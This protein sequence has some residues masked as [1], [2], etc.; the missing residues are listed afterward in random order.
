[1]VLSSAVAD[2]DNQVM[3]HG[4]KLEAL[5]AI[6]K[7]I[8]NL[9]KAEI[10]QA[11]KKLEDLCLRILFQEC[12]H[13]LVR[14][15]V[16]VLSQ[17]YSRGTNSAMHACVAFLFQLCVY[18][19]P[20]GQLDRPIPGNEDSTED[21][22]V[23]IHER[24]VCFSI[25]VGI[26]VSKGPSASYFVPNILGAA[27][28]LMKLPD[29][30]ARESVLRNL[31][32]VI[33]IIGVPGTKVGEE[34]YSQLLYRTLYSDKSPQVRI[35]AAYGLASFCAKCKSVAIANSETIQSLCLKL[36]LAPADQLMESSG[37]TGN[38]LV[39]ARNALSEILLQLSLAII[40]TNKGEKSIPEKPVGHLLKSAVNFQTALA[41][42]MNWIRKYRNSSISTSHYVFECISS[43]AIRLAIAL[44]EREEDL[45]LLARSVVEEISLIS[46]SIAGR[47]IQRILRSGEGDSGVLRIVSE[48]LM[49]FIRSPGTVAEAS[50]VVCL[51]GLVEAMAI[52]ES[53]ICA[54]DSEIGSDLVQLS[55]FC[56]NSTAVA[57]NC[58]YALRSL[59]RVSPS[60]SFSLVN[61]LLNHVTIQNAELA[62]ADKSTQHLF[63]KSILHYAIALSSVLCECADS[64]PQDVSAAVQATAASLICGGQSAEEG[65]N[66]VGEWQRKSCGFILLVPLVKDAGDRSLVTLFSLWKSV[67]GKKTKD[68]LIQAIAPGTVIDDIGPIMECFQ[69]IL[70]ALRSLFAFA[71]CAGAEK[72]QGDT[73][74]MLLVLL[75][76]VWQIT[77]AAVPLESSTVDTNPSLS[78]L[79]HAIRAELYKTLLALQDEQLES[80][81]KPLA[82][83][84]STEVARQD[85]AN[86][87]VF[88]CSSSLLFE[89]VTGHQR[90]DY[91]F[92]P[93]IVDVQDSIFENQ[94]V[95][96]EYA[97]A[98]A[99]NAGLKAMF[100]DKTVPIRD[101]YASPICMGALEEFHSY[102]PASTGSPFCPIFPYL[103][104]D[105]LRPLS[106][107]MVH[108]VTEAR[109]T[110]I[111]LLSR[112][113]GLVD[114]GTCDACISVL[115]SAYR[116]VDQVSSV[117]YEDENFPGKS[118]F[119]IRSNPVVA[120]VA[121][122][123]VVL[124]LSERA[125]SVSESASS[126]LLSVAASPLGLGALHP[127]TRR[128]A[129]GMIAAIY[130]SKPSF[131]DAIFQCVTDSAVSSTARTRSGTAL[132]IANLV[133]VSPM[134]SLTTM[135]SSLFKLTRELT[136]PTRA[137]ALFA[138]MSV[139]SSARASI[140]PWT[141]E[142]VKVAT[143]HAVADIYP[144]ALSTMLLS[145]VVAAIGPVA[146]TWPQTEGSCRC[147]LIWEAIRNG[148]SDVGGQNKTYAIISERF[149][150][151]FASTQ[152]SNATAYVID[153]IGSSIETN[154]AVCRC[155]II[156]LCE[157]LS[158]SAQK[159]SV[160]FYDAL[161]SVCDVNPPLR[162]EVDKLLKV[163]LRSQSMP[164]LMHI[165]N[166]LSSNNTQGGMEEA[167]D[168]DDD[169]DDDYDDG[170]VESPAS[171][172]HHKSATNRS[173][174]RP[175]TVATKAL[176]IKC[177]K[178][179]MKSPLFVKR[180][181]VVEKIVS[182]SVAAMGESSHS[183]AVQGIKLLSLVIDVFGDDVS[184]RPSRYV[185][186]DSDS[187]ASP[188]SDVWDGPVPLLLQFETQIMSALRR[189][190]K[191]NSDCSPQV[192]KICLQIFRK[193]FEKKLT[194]NPE[195]LVELLVQPLV[196]VDPS[197][198]PWS[199]YF[200]L[201]EAGN[202]I[203]SGRS[204]QTAEREVS[205][206]L[207]T[208]MAVIVDVLD[209]AL[210]NGLDVVVNEFRRNSEFIHYYFLR[211]LIDCAAVINGM[212][213]LAY[214]S[215]IE[216][217]RAAL[218][219]SIK[220]LL[221]PT[222]LNGLAISR[223][224]EWGKIWCPL[225]CPVKGV[226][227][228]EAFYVAVTRQLIEDSLESLS[229]VKM[230]TLVRPIE[231]C[232]FELKEEHRD[233]SMLSFFAASVPVGADRQCPQ[234]EMTRF[235]HDL[236]SSHE[237][238]ARPRMNIVWNL[239]AGNFGFDDGLMSDIFLWL[240]QNGYFSTSQEKM[241][242][243]VAECLL[244]LVMKNPQGT[245]KLVRDMT[246]HKGTIQSLSSAVIDLFCQ[247]D[248][249]Q[250]QFALVLLIPVF[251]RSV[252][253]VDVDQL[254]KLRR[255]IAHSKNLSLMCQL[256]VK[257]MQATPP[258]PIVSAFHLPVCLDLLL[259]DR[260]EALVV[261]QPLALV[262][263]AHK[264]STEWASF[265]AAIMSMTCRQENSEAEEDIIGKC[266]ITCMQMSIDVFKAAIAELSAEDKGLVEVVV[267]KH[268]PRR[269]QSS[270]KRDE[271]GTSAPSGTSNAP[272]I[273]LKLKFGQ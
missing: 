145:G 32:S 117:D 223:K 17:C 73:S 128:M 90:T 108:P 237:D 54:L 34:V 50:L 65:V 229:V 109:V 38:L 75:N 56:V 77:Q 91:F 261:L 193:I 25:A 137:C 63:I 130:F 270:S 85:A 151:G 244:P 82:A 228:M 72:L 169:E 58:A 87:A 114:K 258:L 264:E 101:Y 35:A 205:L 136:L 159:I 119:V 148:V 8:P 15:I 216:S 106:D 230:A 20:K 171:V 61:V 51:V 236:I 59:C 122:T 172:G 124:F 98:V 197:S 165:L 125:H 190:V 221:A 76:N 66:S 168:D 268:V 177:V 255:A 225:D 239:T 55:T 162:P 53:S 220:S 227:D 99:V 152:S 222:V 92:S 5:S 266:L 194:S 131:R 107:Q 48:V 217:D 198:L 79:V 263:G 70:V 40:E 187:N 191:T 39:E 173:I 254:S 218:E 158:T 29:P 208:R 209:F 22:N 78:L 161:F 163:L 183:L 233:S 246:E 110:G 43:L 2:A 252:D 102:F 120:A 83:F 215:L 154:S 14:L 267:R 9:P 68:D 256:M 253:N 118:S 206:I 127:M 155:A 199:T 142:V 134:G 203:L 200:V 10:I 135:S 23:S 167:G 166:A 247:V 67:I 210:R 180:S 146:V 139:C 157:I 6:D 16:S 24:V 192:Q 231:T 248:E 129:A 27:Q 88:R 207:Y 30:A 178:R 121:A 188:V 179:I 4:K 245:L 113:L 141:R 71:S 42:M 19:P 57:V 60:V 234:F 251:I 149:C 86:V 143:A 81:M 3:T 84:L 184:Q 126:S 12:P 189:G 46:V 240:L 232:V 41:V 36:M 259:R 64:L 257:L 185:G 174:K 11:Q 250:V 224:L 62:G 105:P 100:I 156:A 132:L 93:E 160:S 150:V 211:L 272:Q 153:A 115:V 204:P 1:M 175:A 13:V 213:G 111:R 241:N 95:E 226:T 273:Q 147:S 144:S 116:A 31:K 94:T 170:R 80:I 45:I 28:R 104:C 164:A 238:I 212:K 97:L 181:D 214:F 96:F 140:A 265:V 89:E 195:K 182:V 262:L 269:D 138:L 21:G 123:T 260:S 52:V 271:D 44:G 243:L 196:L 186:D 219:T 47:C 201:R 18:N 69:T 37:F 202:T 176:M 7:L 103:P 249:G 49:P 133:Q 33:D 74:K 112:L 235:A 26:V 242:T